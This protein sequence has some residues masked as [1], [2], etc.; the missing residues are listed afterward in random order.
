VGVAVLAA[1]LALSLQVVR[2]LF[3]LAFRLSEDIGSI[4][5]GLVVAGVFL[6]GAV[7][8][9]LALASAGDR[10]TVGAVIALAAA[11]GAIQL[12][13]PIPVWLAMAAT[14]AAVAALVVALGAGVAGPPHRVVQALLLGSALDTGMRGAF[15]TWDP[16]WQDGLAPL[17]MGLAL[18]AVAVVLALRTPADPVAPPSV[19]GLLA[20]G[21]FL[22]LHAVF[23][24]APAFVSSQALVG[25]E[26]ALL[27]IL[28]ADALGIL[29]AEAAARW[30]GVSF[31]AVGLVGVVG[32]RTQT[33]PEVLTLV[34]LSTI[35]SAAMLA[36]ALR[37]RRRM[38]RIPLAAGAGGALVAFLALALTYQLAYDVDLGFPNRFLLTTSALVLLALGIT[39]RFRSVVAVPPKGHMLALAP[40]GLLVVPA[41]LFL[42]SAGRDLAPVTPP[43]AL[44][45]AAYNVHLGVRIADG[46]VDLE[47]YADAI[48]GL[49]A[50]VVVLNEVGRGWPVNGLTDVAEWLSARLDLPY[51]WSPAADGQMGNA[52]AT[53]LP[54]AATEV[55][56]L[57]RAGGKMVRSYAIATVPAAGG[58][59]R[60][61]GTHLQ[62]L[63]EHVGSRLAQIEVLL[64]AIGDPTVTVVAGD[65]NAEPGSEE[66]ARLQDTGLRLVDNDVPTSWR[67]ETVI[68]HVLVGPGLGADGLEVPDVRTSDHRPII[69]SVSVA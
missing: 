61:V 50:D 36:M 19:R 64:E 43:D 55:G 12:V 48:E 65:M 54:V 8:G 59:V 27:V 5:A 62:H 16:A 10:S 6:A 40:I 56:P 42:S 32:L 52:I 28:V 44:R 23:L 14:G 21:P 39:G 33:G 11:R 22:F 25:L 47:A 34:G 67:E 18:P 20:V 7:I 31:L 17:V 46:N 41:G 38:G 29:A 13:H 58:D 57:P 49:H 37:P 53:R 24:N 9:G 45:V 3:P 1:V 69:V 15:R 60:V 68:D 51:V 63:D 4:D 66:L 30:R 26:A 35:G 2:V